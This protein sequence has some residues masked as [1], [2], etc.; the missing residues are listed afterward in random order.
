MIGALT[1]IMFEGWF[2]LKGLIG[3]RRERRDFEGPS[4]A[5]KY[6]RLSNAWRVHKNVARDIGN[7]HATSPA[8]R[9]SSRS[10][11]SSSQNASPP[12]LDRW[13]CA[14]SGCGRRLADNRPLMG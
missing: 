9:A 11:I 13:G 8:S 12:R 4:P 5:K 2:E 3:T 6:D 1:P 7:R 10:A 14:T